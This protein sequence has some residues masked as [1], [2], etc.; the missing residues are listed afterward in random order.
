MKL[1]VQ[2]Y[3]PNMSF[4]GGSDSKE[5]ACSAG[6]LGSIPGLGRSPG[7]GNGYPLQYSCLEKSMDREDCS[8]GK[9]K[10]VHGIANYQT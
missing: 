10:S 9:L 8:P 3:I 6:E 4:P 1:I 7:E 2:S 5:F